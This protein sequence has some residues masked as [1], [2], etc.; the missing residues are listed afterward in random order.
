MLEGIA[1][2][3]DD[4]EVIATPPTPRKPKMNL[5]ELSS[6]LEQFFEVEWCTIEAISASVLTNI[7]SASVSLLAAP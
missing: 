4:N 5:T 7:S 3:E 1:L 6:P 2:G